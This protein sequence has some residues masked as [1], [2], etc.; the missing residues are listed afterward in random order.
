MVDHPPQ[1]HA[2][3]TGVD[4][5]ARE[6]LRRGD[7]IVVNI[8]FTEEVKQRLRSDGYTVIV[9]PVGTKHVVEALQRTGA[10]LGA[11][12]NGHYYFTRHVP[13]SDGIYAAALLSKLKPGSVLKFSQEFRNVMLVEAVRASIDFSKLA[14][15]AESSGAEVNTMDGVHADF[16]GF[17]LLMRASNTEPI[18][19]INSEAKNKEL[20]AKGMAVAKEIL[21]A[22][23]AI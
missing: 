1:V 17:I 4:L 16:G 8:D 19:R 10:R 22:C 11:E 2:K 9:C 12:R 18:V 7:K 5:I 14:S 23:K 3:A 6:V 13:D 20:A 21:D 15:L